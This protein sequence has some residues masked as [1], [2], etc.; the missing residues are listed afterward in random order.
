MI[1]RQWLMAAPIALLMCVGCGASREVAI[2]GEVSSSTSS[3]LEGPIAV[4][5]FDLAD[6]AKPSLVHSIKLEK[7]AAF[8]A[9]AS[10][11]GDRVLVRAIQDGDGNGACSAGEAWAE[12]R[13]TIQEDDTV[14][15]VNLDLKVADCPFE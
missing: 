8:D 12:A 1:V 15:A 14:D 6:E 13:A 5:F 3:Q 9:K 11:G 2:Q 10:L 7:L 4:Q